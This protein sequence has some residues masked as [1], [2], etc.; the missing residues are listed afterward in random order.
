MNKWIRAHDRPGPVWGPLQL[1]YY[2]RYY[3][4]YCYCHYYTTTTDAAT[5]ATAPTTTTTTSNDACKEVLCF[6]KF[7]DGFLSGTIQKKSW[8][9][10]VEARA[11]KCTSYHFGHDFRYA[12]T[13][14]P[15]WTDMIINRLSDSNN[16]VKT[17]WYDS[18]YAIYARGRRATGSWGSV[19]P[20]FFEYAVHMRRLTPHFLSAILTLTP[21]FC[22]PPR[23][24]I[25][26]RKPR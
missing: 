7:R 12:Q 13:N 8:V 24:L 16:K 10:I 25:Y 1:N 15:Y 3:Y 22:Y 18:K 11:N 2:Y 17:I 19:D 23:P 14:M 6:L 5:T 9:G 21:T 26:A 4:N 20:H